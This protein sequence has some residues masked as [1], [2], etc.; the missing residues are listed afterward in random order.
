MILVS[1]VITTHKRAPKLVERALNSILSQTYKNIEIIVVD[2]S[3]AEYELRSQVA[4][5]VEKYKERGVRYIQH[6]K[7]M[8]A[9]AARN[10]G[11]ENANG[12]FIAYLDDD[13]IWL[14]GKIEKQLACFD[15]DNV[16][17]VYCGSCTE[18]AD[19]SITKRPLK[20]LEGNVFDELVLMNFI[21]STS[22][23]LIRKSALEDIGGFDVLMQSVQDGDVW[24]R[25]AKKYE[26]RCANDVLVQ[27]TENPDECIT[28]NPKKK[29]AGLERLNYKLK[30]YLDTHKYAKWQRNLFIVPYYA[31]DKRLGKA[32]CVWFKYIW[33]NPKAIKKNILFFYSACKKYFKG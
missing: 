2:D 19:K 7:C 10:T 11:L 12:E 20:V 13:D 27:Y 30:D 26:I 32:F 21:G 15:S 16:A 18:H 23:P 17:L 33:L 9:C 22:F 1:A 3:P 25:L 5:T 14:E 8:G 29:I 4:Q 31:A 28:K 6:E 24:I